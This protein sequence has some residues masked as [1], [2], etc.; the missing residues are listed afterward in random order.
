[1]NGKRKLV[2]VV[3]DDDTEFCKTMMEILEIGLFMRCF[4]SGFALVKKKRV[5]IDG[6]SFRSGKCC[7][8]YSDGTHNAF[9]YV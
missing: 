9:V 7:I 4:Y 8:R 5:R 6:V 1:M 2:K 3:M